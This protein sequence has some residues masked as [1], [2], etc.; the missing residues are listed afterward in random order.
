MK[1][2]SCEPMMERLTFKDLSGFDLVVIGGASAS[3]QTTAF[4]PEW[5]WVYH[6]TKQAY[7][8]KCSVYWKENLTVRPKE[9]PV[10]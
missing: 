3:T 10:K 2:L 1:S 4:Q 6:L 9:F 7:D 5:E 8:A